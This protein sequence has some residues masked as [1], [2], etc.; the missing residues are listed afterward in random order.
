VT[1]PV[2]PGDPLTWLAEAATQQHELFIA[3]VNAGFT[4]SE[5]LR[6]LIAVLLQ[7]QATGTE[8]PN[9]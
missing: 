2:P 3:W 7:G 1:Q 8:H 4:R 6:M 9:E 5:A